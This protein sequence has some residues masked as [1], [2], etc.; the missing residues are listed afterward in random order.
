MRKHEIIK[1]CDGCIETNRLATSVTKIC[2]FK[3]LFL[4]SVQVVKTAFLCNSC[5]LYLSAE[6][7]KWD[8]TLPSKN[9]AKSIIPIIRCIG[10]HNQNTSKEHSQNIWVF[11]RSGALS[12]KH[13]I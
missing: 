7:R 5:M 2:V 11:F 13:K 4:Y 3:F 6:L 12:H 9:S 1:F 8:E 10:I